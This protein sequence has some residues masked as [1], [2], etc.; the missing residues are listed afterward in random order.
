MSYREDKGKHKDSVPH[1]LLLE[2]TTVVSRSVMTLKPVLQAKASGK[3][4]RPFSPEDYGYVSVYCLCSALWGDCLPRTVSDCHS[5]IGFRKTSSPCH[6]S[7]AVKWSALYGLCMFVSF[8]E[9]VKST[10]TVYANQLQPGS[11]L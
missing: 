4:N 11:P 3:L 2:S 8:R 9:A 1:P 5:P 10:G 6:Q 7:Q